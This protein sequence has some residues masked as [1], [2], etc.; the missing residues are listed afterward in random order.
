MSC[1]AALAEN[2]E[3]I[4]KLFKTKEV[5]A[6]GCYILNL[7]VNGTWQDVAVD[8]FFPINPNTKNL[9]FGHAKPLDGIPVLW[10]ALLEKAWAK[11]AGNYD[12]TINGTIDVGFNHLCGVPS[13]ELYNIL[14]K[15]KKD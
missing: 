6:A 4:K 10:V 9:V 14:Y 5:N 13:L 3:R 2:P 8:D 15:A 11:L 7:C 12:R 1:L